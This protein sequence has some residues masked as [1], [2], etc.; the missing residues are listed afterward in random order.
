MSIQTIVNNASSIT[1][2]RHKTSGQT[3]SRSGELRTAELAS[4]IPWLFTVEM[5]N[6]LAYST[7]RAVTEEIDRLDRTI[8]E[9]INIGNTN[10]GLAYITR[11]QGDAAGITSATIANV[12]G[13]N[14]YL[15]C[16]SIGAGSGYLFRKGDYIQPSGGYRYPYTVTADVAYST[17]S[18]VTIPVNRPT[19]TQALYSFPGKG[20][21]VGSNV[22]W[23][24]KML[25][26]PTY[27]IVPYDRIQWDSE[28]QL[29]EIIV[30]AN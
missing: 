21:V 14:I 11:Y 19:I 27:T 23:R 1:I 26:K 2:D 16:S 10:T 29:I 22:S 5:H 30:S 6:G 13:S 25:K 7:N 9:E 20:I 8:E 15:N 4:N 12:S 3:I 28:F 24:V 18:N 17:S